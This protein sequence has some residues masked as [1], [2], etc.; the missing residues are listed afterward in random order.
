MLPCSLSFLLLR[1]VAR[2]MCKRNAF[3]MKLNRRLK[4]HNKESSVTRSSQWT[5]SVMTD[6][7]KQCI[8]ISG[9]NTLTTRDSNWY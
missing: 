2:V 9:P 1:F 5:L 8:F 6:S 7:V 4:T 3:Q